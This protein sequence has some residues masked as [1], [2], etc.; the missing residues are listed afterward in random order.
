MLFFYFFAGVLPIKDKKKVSETNSATY[1]AL[2]RSKTAPS[3][4]FTVSC[5]KMCFVGIQN[6][7]YLPKKLCVNNEYWRT[8]FRSL[9]V[10]CL[11]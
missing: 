3:A 2:L 11:I 5:N 4:Y 1:N 7:R 9:G 6:L 8:V 10:Y